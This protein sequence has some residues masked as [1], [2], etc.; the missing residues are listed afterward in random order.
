LSKRLLNEMVGE[1]LLMNLSS[2]AAVLATACS[3]ESAVEGLA[4]F[5]D[6]RPPK[7]P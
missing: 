4:S 3:T 2:G 7:F 6:K 5:V 1:S